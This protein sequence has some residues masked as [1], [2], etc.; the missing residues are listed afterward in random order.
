MQFFTLPVSHSLSVSWREKENSSTD[1]SPNTM[2]WYQRRYLTSSAFEEETRVIHR[3]HFQSQILQ[4]RGYGMWWVRVKK[5]NCS[6]LDIHGSKKRQKKK[7]SS[8]RKVLLMG[9]WRIDGVWW[10]RNTGTDAQINYSL[11]SSALSCQLP[12][13]QPVTEPQRLAQEEKRRAKKRRNG[14]DGDVSNLKFWT[15]SW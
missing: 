6:S 15:G 8:R 5:S 13:P 9:G 10:I 11:H 12:F 1:S 4:L 2:L 7:K 3:Y 14:S